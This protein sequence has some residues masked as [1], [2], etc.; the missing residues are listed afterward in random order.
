MSCGGQGRLPGE[1]RRRLKELRVNAVGPVDEA[2]NE[3][4]IMILGGGSSRIL[5]AGYPIW[6]LREWV[7]SKGSP[8]GCAR[9]Q[10]SAPPEAGRL[11]KADFPFL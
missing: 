7:G 1:K 5:M 2:C 6:K 10:S 9:F 3:A 8:L 4:A 11:T